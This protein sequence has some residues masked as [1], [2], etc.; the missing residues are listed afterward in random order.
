[1]QK[2]S[3]VLLSCLIPAFFQSCS[4]DAGPRAHGELSSSK[5]TSA[6]I[7]ESPAVPVDAWHAAILTA[8][9]EYEDYGRVDDM[10]R[11]APLLCSIKPGKARLSDAEPETPHARKLY[12]LFAKDR[13]SYVKAA[14]EPSPVGQVIVK[15]AWTAREESDFDPSKSPIVYRGPNGKIM[16]PEDGKWYSAG[17]PSGLF[18]MMKLDP[19]TPGTDRGWVYATTNPAGDAIVRA[20]ALQDC[21]ACHDGASEHDR[22]FGIAAD[23]WE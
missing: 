2:R 3:L 11:F 6:A 15:E 10:N 8:A 5:A 18:V 20:G 19:E 23:D 9:S 14:E 13:A 21:M 16:A 12:Y 7:I 1:M 17:E 22:L 4:P